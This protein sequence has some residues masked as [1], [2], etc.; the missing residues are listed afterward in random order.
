MARPAIFKPNPD[1]VPLVEELREDG[2]S[3]DDILER[4]FCVGE[5]LP[6]CKGG[7]ECD[8]WQY[9]PWR[10][11]DCGAVHPAEEP[12]P[13]PDCYTPYFC[14]SG[15]LNRLYTDD[16][17]GEEDNGEDDDVQEG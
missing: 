3:T 10:C 4:L 8:C 14:G 1:L 12:G 15:E 5:H 13:C 11:P 16:I 9:L 2:V 6:T 17:V 7:D